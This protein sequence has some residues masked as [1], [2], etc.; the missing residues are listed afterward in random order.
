[1]KIAS[2]PLQQLDGRFRRAARALSNGWHWWTDQLHQLC[3]PVLQRWLRPRQ[4]CCYLFLDDSQY[5]LSATHTGVPSERID[6][7]QE[8][9]PPN[10]RRRIRRMRELVLVIPDD[11][12]L[13]VPLKLPLAARDHLQRVLNYQM[14]VH[15]PF[16]V[17]QVLFDYQI[18]KTDH[19][20][21]TLELEMQV[22]PRERLADHQQRLQHWSLN[23]THLRPASMITHRH[24]NLLGE[25]DVQTRQRPIKRLSHA[26]LAINAMLL[27]LAVALPLWHK[28]RLIDGMQDAKQALKHDA[29]EVLKIRRQVEQLQRFQQQLTT[30]SQEQRHMLNILDELTRRLPDDAWVN[31][32]ELNDGTLQLQGEATNASS[33]ISQIDG[34]NLFNEVSF[35]APV[36]RNPRSNKERYV[37][38]AELIGEAHK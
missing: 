1:M 33:L 23:L 24:C 22:V 6:F 4:I 16:Q 34:S 7:T 17:D 29:E 28:D 2:Q 35:L 38:N 12:V 11:Q 36:T 14:S 15:T 19:D 32:L 27:A 20:T 9:L 3:P 21:E 26:L 31:R 30:V 25:Q 5:R 10:I 37:I 13:R 18:L 8:K